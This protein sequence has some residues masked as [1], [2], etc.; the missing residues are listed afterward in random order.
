[1]VRLVG[2]GWRRRGVAPLSATAGGDEQPLD[3]AALVEAYVEALAAT[4]RRE[5]GRLAVRAFEWFLGRNRLGR[6]VYDFSTGG[7]HDGLG[8]SADSVSSITAVTSAIFCCDWREIMLPNTLLPTKLI[9]CTVVF[10]PS[11]TT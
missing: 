1:M 5:H 10:A 8:E 9:C 3:A 2:N 4:G 11:V 6:A 7:C